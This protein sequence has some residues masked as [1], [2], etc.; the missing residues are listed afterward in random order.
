[1]PLKA[2]PETSVFTNRDRHTRR[3]ENSVYN[4]RQRIVTR[5]CVTRNHDVELRHARYEIRCLPCVEYMRASRPD[6]NDHL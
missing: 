3:A 6:T 1:M 4:K 2:S 5:R